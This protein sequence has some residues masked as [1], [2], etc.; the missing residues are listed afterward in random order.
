MRRPGE[1]MSEPCWLPVSVL[2]L[3]EILVFFAGLGWLGFQRLARRFRQYEWADVLLV[4][5]FGLALANMGTFL[6][7]AFAAPR[8]C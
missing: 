5:L 8:F 4:L 6:L 3:P 2:L 7:Y 1:V